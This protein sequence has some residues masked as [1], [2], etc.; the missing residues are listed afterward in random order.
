MKRKYLRRIGGFILGALMI[1]G[2][3][4]LFS[5]TTA[6][7]QNR[8]RRAIIVRRYDPFWDPW[9]YRRPFGYDDF[10]WRYNHYVF[11]SSEK[12]FNQGYKDGLKTGKG[13]LK[14]R[15]TYD[16][17]RSHYFQEAGFGNFGEVYRN[18]FLRGYA[19][20]FRA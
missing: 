19:D 18:G 8:R 11:S 13:D 1:P 4:M 20:G 5:N 9:G 2:V 15:R 10:R 12:A 3:V 16:P 6:E 7:A 14:N 17:E